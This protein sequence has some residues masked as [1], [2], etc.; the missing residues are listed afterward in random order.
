MWKLGESMQMGHCAHMYFWSYRL[1]KILFTSIALL[2]GFKVN[3][4][5]TV[6]QSYI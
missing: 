3:E 4:R 5:D 2:I 1:M 6:M